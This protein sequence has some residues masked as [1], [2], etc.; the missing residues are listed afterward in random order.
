M[1]I[2]A[3]SVR[4]GVTV[5]RDFQSRKAGLQRAE[6]VLQFGQFARAI[7][8]GDGGIDRLRRRRDR[9]DQLQTP[10][11]RSTPRRGAD[12]PSPPG[13]RSDDGLRDRAEFATGSGPAGRR[14]ARVPSPRSHPPRSARAGCAIAVRSDH[15]C[16][17][18]D[19][20]AASRPRARATTTSAATARTRASACAGGRVACGGTG[21]VS[22]FFRAIIHL[23]I[24]N[25]RLQQSASRPIFALQQANSV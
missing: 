3:Y 24:G 21:T 25:C 4:L 11:P 18:T 13:A 12:R 5:H 20:T 10:L 2:C 8:S 7:T 17:A 16:A 19:G 14:P 23:H 22:D 1:Q 9:L 6:H 15:D